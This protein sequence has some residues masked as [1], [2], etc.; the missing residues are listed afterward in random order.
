MR[1]RRSEKD[2]EYE[3]N[4]LENQVSDFE[5]NI[6]KINQKLESIENVVAKIGD[7]QSIQGILNGNLQERYSEKDI[8]EKKAD[9]LRHD[10]EELLREIADVEAINQKSKQEIEGLDFLGEDLS[11]ARSIISERE[12]WVQDA[13]QRVEDLIRRLG[14]NSFHTPLVGSSISINQS[15]GNLPFTNQTHTKEL[16]NGKIVTVFDHPKVSVKNA[17]FNQGSAYPNKFSGTCGCCCCATL[18]RKAGFNVDEKKV[19]DYASS[20]RDENGSSLCMKD[21]IFSNEN[22]GTNFLGRAKIIKGM[23]G[24]DVRAEVIPLSEV[25]KYVETGHGVI[26]G[27]NAC[28]YAPELYGPYNPNTPGGHALILE[29]VV[30]DGLSREIVG[31]YV[32]DSNGSTAESAC[33]FIEANHLTKAFEKQGCRANITERIIW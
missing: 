28:I 7:D 4:S 18:M 6:S 14:N 20:K 3:I 16:I 23:S 1:E 17:I 5:M 8:E 29:S 19:V 9:N 2:V 32:I 27:V 31:Y 25:A 24:L 30:R 15:R 12:N 22:G 10:L 26:I 13:Q 11:D 33:R 21:S